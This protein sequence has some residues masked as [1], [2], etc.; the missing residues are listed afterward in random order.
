MA[1]TSHERVI[2]G[3]TFRVVVFGAKQGRSVLLRL[4]KMVG[5]SLGSFV[6][7][8]GRGAGKDADAAVAL[9][10]GEAMHELAARLAQS[11]VEG[12]LDELAKHTVVVL[13]GD[14]EPRLS[15]VFDDLFAGRYQDMVAWA[16]FALEVNYAGFFGGSGPGGLLSRLMTLIPQASPSPSTSTGTSGES[17]AAK[18]SASV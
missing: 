15:D 12:I 7:G 10:I 14:K 3:T 2:G 13:P 16:A 4:L 8:L 11:E 17:S 18:G 9:G 5:P 6:G 1:I